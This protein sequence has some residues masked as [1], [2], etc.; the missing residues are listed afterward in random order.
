MI[1]KAL[2][3][4]EEAYEQCG[5]APVAPTR[6][7]RFAIAYLANRS[8]DRH[9]F[10]DFWRAVTGG[11]DAGQNPTIVAGLRQSRASSALHQIYALHGLRR[12]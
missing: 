2:H 1:A 9:P 7:L 6:T 10:D 4:L 12:P 5:A 8:V 3:A 11:G